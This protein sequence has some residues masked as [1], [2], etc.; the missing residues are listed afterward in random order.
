MRRREFLHDLWYVALPSRAL[1]RGRLVGKTILG[2][3]IV[4]GR[5]EAGAPFALR[6]RCPHRGM[7]LRHGR[8]SAG[9]VECCY[10]GWRFGLEDGACRLIPSL[11]ETDEVC[12]ERV[13]IP[14]YPC[15]ESGSWVWIFMP[16]PS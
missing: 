15:R 2:E 12:V 16:E 5:N 3:A 11:A 7:P 6:D 9:T 10:H 4:F 8:I 14:T 13:R 1:R